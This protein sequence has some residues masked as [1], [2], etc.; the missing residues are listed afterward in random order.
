MV[1]FR[2]GWHADKNKPHSRPNF[3]IVHISK[4]LAALISQKQRSFVSAGLVSITSVGFFAGVTVPK[5]EFYLKI[6]LSYLNNSV[7]LLLPLFGLRYSKDL[8]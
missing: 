5:T 1:L 2:V 6:F 4:P 7:V 8:Y 3:S